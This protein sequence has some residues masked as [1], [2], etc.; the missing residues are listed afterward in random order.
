MGMS[1]YDNKFGTV[2]HS[3]IKSRYI[4]KQVIKYSDV[5]S[6]I[7]DM[8]NNDLKYELL[9]QIGEDFIQNYLRT[10]KINRIMKR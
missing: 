4:S 10:K 9:D 1:I 8:T 6:F 5:K 7:T 3:Y 2:D